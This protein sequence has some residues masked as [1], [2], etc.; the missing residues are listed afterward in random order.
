[1][2]FVASA[3][4]FLRGD[5]P[6]AALPTQPACYVAYKPGPTADVLGLIEVDGQATFDSAGQLR[7]TT[8][9]VDPEVTP[10]EFWN[11]VWDPTVDY[12][13]RD[14]VFP[15]NVSTEQYNAYNAALM[16]ESQLTATIAGLRYSGL[17]VDLTYD[18]ARVAEVIED[19]P[20]E[21]LLEVDDLV[22]AV[23][24]V[25]V[26]TSSEV[27]D[28]LTG[29]QPGDVVTL[30]VQDLDG[31][32]SREVEITTGDNPDAP[33][34]P[35][36]GVLLISYLDLPFDVTID[37]GRIGGSSAGLMF[38]LGI[39]DRL[40]DEDLTTGKVI[41]GTG[42]ID[43]QGNVAPIGGIR[44]KIAAASRGDKPA[45]VFLTPVRNFEEAKTASAGNPILLVPVA[46]LGDA[47]TALQQLGAG[48]TPQ[49]SVQLGG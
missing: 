8:V 39:V 36:L 31:T 12:V 46:T 33:G 17:D 2:L 29:K 47:V 28:V 35:F 32:N 4:L 49:G 5:V 43:D 21:G 13:D 10:L 3:A 42:E 6:C 37:S 15:P 27:I 23:D 14:V 11:Y 7:L 26:T 1:M 41:A 16:D 24:G 38:A 48:E 45:E 34:R 30:T 18:G 19:S 20:S 9:L 22:V 44:Q 40:G 25:T